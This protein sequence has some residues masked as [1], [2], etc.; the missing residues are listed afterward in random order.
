MHTE[1]N[2]HT[3]EPEEQPDDEAVAAKDTEQELDPVE[4]LKRAM[5]QQRQ[6]QQQ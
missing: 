1:H 6:Q 2:S 3:E 5:E 4:L